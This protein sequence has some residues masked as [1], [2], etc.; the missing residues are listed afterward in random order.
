MVTM[1]ISL[2]KKLKQFADTVVGRGLYASHSE[3]VRDMLRRDR[4]VLLVDELLLAGLRSPRLSQKSTDTFLRKMK[5]G[6][7]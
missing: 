2:D 7:L 5:K 1:N 6:M 3:Y 4:A